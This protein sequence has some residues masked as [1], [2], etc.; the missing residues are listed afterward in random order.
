MGIQLF[1]H[2]LKYSINFAKNKI[3]RCL[4]VDQAEDQPKEEKEERS[5]TRQSQGHLELDSNFQSEEFIDFFEKETTPRELV[6]EHL[7]T[8]LLLWN[9]WLLKSWNWQVMQLVTIR[10]LGSSQDTCSLPS[11]TTKNWTS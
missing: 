7:F 5:R 10:R 4:P 11:E 6:L 1:Q 8:W 2:S 3:S 9:T